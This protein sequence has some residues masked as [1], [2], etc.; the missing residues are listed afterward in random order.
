MAKCGICTKDVAVSLYLRVKPMWEI[1]PGRWRA[2][3]KD[4]HLFLGYWPKGSHLAEYL[5][6]EYAR[7]MAGRPDAILQ[8]LW[9]ANCHG[10]RVDEIIEAIEEKMPPIPG[11]AVKILWNPSPRVTPYLLAETDV[12]RRAAMLE[13]N[14]DLRACLV[15]EKRD[16]REKVYALVNNSVDRVERSMSLNGAA[17]RRH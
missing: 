2:A 4:A 6:M 17:A 7:E 12:A 11:V 9:E 5:R 15:T 16:V 13:V 1:R 3:K 8:R 10:H 14:N